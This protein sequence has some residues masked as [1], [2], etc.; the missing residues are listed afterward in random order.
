MRDV[1]ERS[2]RDERCH[3]DA[4]EDGFAAEEQAVSQRFDAIVLDVMLTGRDGF[5]VCTR[6]R[7]RG[8]D[9][10]ILLLSARGA[11]EDRVRGLDLG[12]GHDVLHA[13]GSPC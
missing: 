4:V 11:L 9:T 2:L 7:A 6:L 3:V 5:E 12:P 8:I 13:G 10:P 1:L